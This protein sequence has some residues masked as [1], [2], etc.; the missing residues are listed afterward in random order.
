[1]VGSVKDYEVN[2]AYQYVTD[3]RERLMDTCTLAQEQLSKA[4]IK[5]KKYYNRKARV[6][7]FR[8]CSTVPGVT[9]S[10]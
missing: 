10:W 7:I 9:T 3:F 2:S 4:K 5:Q 8:E 6:R 1:M